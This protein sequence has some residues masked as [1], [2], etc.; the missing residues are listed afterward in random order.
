[1]KSCGL[2]RAAVVQGGG[3]QGSYAGKPGIWG[4]PALLLVMEQRA[5][6]QRGRLNATGR[7]LAKQ[8]GGGRDEQGGGKNMAKRGTGKENLPTRKL[9]SASS[10]TALSLHDSSCAGHG[11]CLDAPAGSAVPQHTQ[12]HPST[13]RQQRASTTGRHRGGD[14]RT[15]EQKG[16]HAR[17][18]A[19]EI[20]QP[21]E[22][23]G[24]GRH[25]LRT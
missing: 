19:V 21:L 9:F 10:V 16:D 20:H 17:S 11:H 22:D 2:H 15:P 3:Q 18:E 5:C 13:G 24:N 8:A 1:M 25:C 14:I 7:P 23:G 4:R 6:L 12:P